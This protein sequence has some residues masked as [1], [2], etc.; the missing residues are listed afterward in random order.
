MMSNRTFWIAW[1]LGLLLLTAAVAA[2]ISQWNL[3]RYSQVM[4]DRLLLLA[5]L[6]HGAVQSYFDTAAA[7]LRFWSSSPA[8]NQLQAQLGDAWRESDRPAI[9]RG[10]RQRYIAANPHPA[11]ERAELARAGDSAYDTLHAELHGMAREFVTERGYYDLFLIDGDGYIEYS[12]GKEDD[13]ATSLSNGPYRETA[14]AAVYQEARDNP[15]AIAISDIQRYAPSAEAPALFIAT[16]LAGD[17][18]GVLALQLPMDS[19]LEIMG[20]SGGMG[21]TGETYLVGQDHLMRSDSRFMATSTV[22][23]QAV[24]TDTVRRALAGEQGVATTVDYR[25]VEVLS[26]FVPVTVGNQRWAILA[27]IDSAEI[28][29]GAAAERPA[30]AG[31]LSLFYGLS[32]WSIWYSRGRELP[33]EIAADGGATGEAALDIGADVGGMGSP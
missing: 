25:G 32:L 18:G 28:R 17:T 13:F 22:L 4:A 3:S 1:A 16:S 2:G 11:G 9:A 5:E 19:L 6:R 27:E 15:G 29:T 14:L 31:I 23:V 8:L 33:N 20:Y 24:D 21:D 26:A 12:V 10:L 30:L 7:E